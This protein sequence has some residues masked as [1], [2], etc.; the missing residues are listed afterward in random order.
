MNNKPVFLHDMHVELVSEPI[1]ESMIAYSARASLG[2]S[3]DTSPDASLSQADT[4]L[5]E[6]LWADGHTTPFE[7]IAVTM[8]MEIPLFVHAQLVKHRHSTINTQSGR[9]REFEPRF[10]IPSASR[11][12]FQS[13]KAIEYNMLS[14]D[15]A[16]GD[17]NRAR[18]AVADG[19]VK[20]CSEWYELYSSLLHEHGVARE[21]AR[22]TMPLNTYTKCYVT[23]NLHG[24]FN[25]LRLRLNNKHLGYETHAQAEI[26][27]VADKVLSILLANYPVATN[28]F[29]KKLT[30]TEDDCRNGSNKD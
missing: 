25:F 15:E 19:M 24:W 7:S 23:M 13:G 1:P 18:R 16:P 12:A 6:T 26:A 9:Y 14:D 27:E 30:N 11:P 20:Q 17:A 2:R 3:F 5:I 4:R 22:M 21:V 8:R 28:A 10:Y 29:V